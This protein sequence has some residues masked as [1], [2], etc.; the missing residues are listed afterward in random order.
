MKLLGSNKDTLTEVFTCGEKGEGAY[1]SFPAFAKHDGRYLVSIDYLKA[2]GVVWEFTKT[3]ENS[4]Y[5]GINVQ[6]SQYSSVY[7]G[8]S[9]KRSF[10]IRG[11]QLTLYDDDVVVVMQSDTGYFV[12]YAAVL[13]VSHA[14]SFPTQDGKI[15]LSRKSGLEG[16][17]LHTYVYNMNSESATANQNKAHEVAAAVTVSGTVDD[18]SVSQKYIYCPIDYPLANWL[19]VDNQ[20]DGQKG[21]FTFYASKNPDTKSDG[22]KAL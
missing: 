22:A 17:N 21:V 5:I 6:D 15:T 7:I 19:V 2:I 20:V 4:Y 13:G 8:T 18:V 9:G 12:D 11:S 10:V 3:G 14:V 1:Q 16:V